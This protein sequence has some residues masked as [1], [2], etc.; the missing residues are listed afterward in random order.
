MAIPCQAWAK[1]GCNR[2][3]RRKSN[4]TLWSFW[5]AAS[6]V[7][8]LKGAVYQQSFI[9]PILISNDFPRR[10]C[11]ECRWKLKVLLSER[12]VLSTGRSV[13]KMLGVRHGG[14]KCIM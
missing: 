11:P 4:L 2:L 10:G 6:T 7:L 3:L 14:D 8:D 1:R 5:P 12:V 9:P 13:R